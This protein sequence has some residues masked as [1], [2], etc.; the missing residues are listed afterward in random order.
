MTTT[1]APPTLLDVVDDLTLPKHN[2]VTQDVMIEVT[3]TETQAVTVRASGRTRK[4]FVTL[5]PLL[6]QLQDAIRSSIGGTA[7]GASLAHERSVLDADALQKAMIIA[8]TIGDWCRLV[9]AH[10][11][12]AD[13]CAS[14]RGWYTKRLATN[15]TQAEDDFYQGQLRGWV[16]FVWAKL[17]PVRERELPDACPTCG[18][19]EW[20]RDGERYHHPL[21]IKYRP[22]DAD[23]IE[24]GRALCRACEQVWGIRELAYALEQ[25][26]AEAL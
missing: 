12:R 11:D 26:Q 2:P 14:L 25:G 18:A 4:G 19:A 17:D 3:D 20:W 23:M 8:S 1:T 5:P 13:M 9:D 21:V 10:H 15:P 16:S 24:R 6:T 7:S 22:N